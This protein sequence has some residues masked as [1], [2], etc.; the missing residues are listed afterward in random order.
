MNLSIQGDYESIFTNYQTLRKYKEDKTITTMPM[1]VHQLLNVNLV[2]HVE[3]EDEIIDK[4][5]KIF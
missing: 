2:I 3:A 5:I 4:Y 1:N